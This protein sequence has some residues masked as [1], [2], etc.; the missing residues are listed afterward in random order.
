MSG[1]AVISAT[2]N[3]A[4]NEDWRVALTLQIDYS[5]SGESPNIQARDL[6][7]LSFRMQIR[8]TE[9]DN[10]ALVSIDSSVGGG[11]EVIAPMAGQLNLTITRA[12]LARLHHS[13]D[14]VFDLIAIEE[15]G[16]IER[17]IE[18]SVVVS[19]GVTR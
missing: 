8:K 4:K 19:E 5:V 11:I 6:T 1:P 15:S 7:G 12:K 14:Y 13:Q 18:G 16:L 3:I 10:T 2:A 9:P 17:L